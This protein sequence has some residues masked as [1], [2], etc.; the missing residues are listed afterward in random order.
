MILT[1]IKY[2]IVLNAIWTYAKKQ[3]LHWIWM[4]NSLMM[5]EDNAT[6]PMSSFCFTLQGCW[7]QEIRNSQKMG[8]MKLNKMSKFVHPHKW[9][10]VTLDFHLDI[11]DHKNEIPCQRLTIKGIVLDIG[12]VEMRH[13]IQ[14]AHKLI[15]F[16]QIEALLSLQLMDFPHHP[17]SKP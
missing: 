7:D 8:K 16:E 12:S 11:T 5:S 3:L 17:I 6:K 4:L 2:P 9:Y 10:P 1:K 15:P 14:G 13:Y